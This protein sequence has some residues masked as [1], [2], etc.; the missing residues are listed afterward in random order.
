MSDNHKEITLFQIKEDGFYKNTNVHFDANGDL[1]FSD[2]V[3]TDQEFIDGSIRDYDHED[4]ATVKNEHVPLLMLLL[5]RDHFGASAHDF[6]EWL[7]KNEIP[8]KYDWWS[9]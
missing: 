5:I 8:Y 1:V 6:R 2:Y 9:G 3:M 7:D 4:G